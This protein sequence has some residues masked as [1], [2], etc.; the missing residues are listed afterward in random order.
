MPSLPVLLTLVRE[1]TTAERASRVP[2]PELVMD[3][4]AQVAAYAEAARPN[5]VLAPVYLFHSAHA[6]E[7]IR[8]GDLV[9]DLA[10]GP[11]NQLA[12]IATLCPDAR[13]IGVDLSETMLGRAR[14][15]MERE[16]IENVELRQGDISRL[17]GI[18][19]G[20]VDAIISSLALHHL[21]TLDQLKATFAEMARV[22]KRGGGVYV[23]DLGHLKSERSI[24]YFA[25]QYADRQPELFTLDYLNSLRA[26][27]AVEDF[28]AAG[29]PIAGAA[30]LYTTFLAPYMIAFKSAARRTLE[31]ALSRRFQ[32]L[33][34]ALP[35]HHRVDLKDLSTFFRLG[36]LS[37]RLLG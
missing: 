35:H 19:T 28:R 8:A 27:F 11:A 3:D 14:D 32:E 4:P 30:R 7:V 23:S 24:E 15:L 20:S 26:A 10:C 25:R 18:A 36:G 1:I 2:E 17:P 33:R 29:A 5:G 6:C 31:P 13:F 9:L 37:S 12:M 34:A 16:G 22:L 21:P